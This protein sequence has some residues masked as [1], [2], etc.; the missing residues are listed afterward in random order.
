MERHPTKA[1]KS[2]MRTALLGGLAMLA[3]SGIAVA[4]ASAYTNPILENAKGEHVSKAKFTGLDEKRSFPV[5]EREL[6]KGGECSKET[7]TGELST[8]GTGAA[9]TTSGTATLLFKN[10]KTSLGKCTTSGRPLGGEVEVKLALSLVWV[11]KESEEKPGLRAAIVP[12]SA[13]PGN[14]EGAKLEMKCW[15]DTFATEGAFIGSQNHGLG[16]EFTEAYF[17]ATSIGEYPEQRYKKYTQEGKEAEIHLYSS[18]GKTDF[19]ETAAEF[20]EEQTYGE[21]VKIAKS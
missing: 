13:K 11:G 9:A 2:V 18:W 20:E 15:G 5:A 17:V 4:S 8:T 3:L 7:S 14:G 6:S 10:C 1:L 16:V 19:E 12:L 21:K